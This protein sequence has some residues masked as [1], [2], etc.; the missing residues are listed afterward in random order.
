MHIVSP[1]LTNLQNRKVVSNTHPYIKFLLR[2]SVLTSILPHHI[3]IIRDYGKQN[4]ENV[5]AWQHAKT[6]LH[7]PTMNYLKLFATS[8]ALHICK[9]LSMSGFSWKTHSLF[10]GLTLKVMKSSS[11]LDNLHGLN[12]RFHG[13]MPCGTV[14]SHSLLV[15][16]R[17]MMN[18]FDLSSLATINPYLSSYDIAYL[19]YEKLLCVFDS[20]SS[21]LDDVVSTFIGSMFIF[22]I[23]NSFEIYSTP[24]SPHRDKRHQVPNLCALSPPLRRYLFELRKSHFRRDVRTNIL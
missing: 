1:I 14:T 11:K 6:F 4:F 7:S 10:T 21:T 9:F 13:T 15:G 23:S 20:R 16:Y 8:L 3:V 2:N 17:I 5:Q 24:T 19:I 22:Q 12:L 18:D